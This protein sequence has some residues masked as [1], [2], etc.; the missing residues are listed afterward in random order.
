MN[1]LFKL[2]TH[3]RVI[4]TA[5]QFEIINNWSKGVGDKYTVVAYDLKY[6]TRKAI[7]YVEAEK[8]QELINQ[9]KIEQIT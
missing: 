9:N 3:W 5:F 6:T 8:M 2:N 7:Q 1:S 4:G